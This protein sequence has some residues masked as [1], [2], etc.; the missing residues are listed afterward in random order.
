MKNKYQ[1]MAF[2]ILGKTLL[3]ALL[4]ITVCYGVLTFFADQSSLLENRPALVL[5]LL[6]AVLFFSLVFFV[7]R[8]ICDL[9]AVSMALKAVIRGAEQPVM[10]PDEL[11]LLEDDL[12][13]LKEELVRRE[14]EAA[15]SEKKK[16][17]LVAYL[18]HDLKTPLTS[19][20]AYLSMLDTQPEMPEEERIKYTH[21]TME[22]RCA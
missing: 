14:Q 19:V 20:L 21:I 3:F 12:A 15:L 7:F 2:A 8:Q 16:N 5:G 1:R 22:K 13:H 18:A 9:N 4:F 6:A 11:Q 10:L 17:E